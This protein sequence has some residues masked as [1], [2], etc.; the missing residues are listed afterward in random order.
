MNHTTNWSINTNPDSMNHLYTI[1]ETI[2]HL[3]VAFLS[4]LLAHLHSV[5]AGHHNIKQSNVKTAVLFI[6][7]FESVLTAVYVNYLVTAS[8]K[9]YDQI[10]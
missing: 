1:D 8:Y 9:V 3:Y 5:D 4:Y 10:L 7:G 2:L 6:I